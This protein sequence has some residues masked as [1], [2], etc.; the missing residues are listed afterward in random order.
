[1]AYTVAP[2]TTV[3]V[4]VLSQIEVRNVTLQPAVADYPT[5]GYALTPGQGISL[6]KIYWTIPEGGQGGIA[7]VWNPTTGKVQMF[8]DYDVQGVPL[9]LGS[10]SVAATQSTYTSAGLLTV[11][12]AN[13]LSPGQFIVFSNGASGT[14]IFLD[15]VMA[16]VQTATPTGYTVNFGQGLAL[17][18]TINTDTLKYQVVQ[19]AAGNLLQAQ[20]LPA[21]ITGVL[22][23]AI[24]LTI[25]QANSLSPGQFVVLGGTFKAA[26][27]YASG[28]VVQVTSATA[29][30]WTAKWQGT[31]IAQ[32]SSEVATSALLVTNGNTPVIASQ[33]IFGAITNTLAV[34]SDATHAGLITL[35]SAQNFAAGNILAIQGVGVNTT[36]N[37]TVATVIASGLTNATIKANGWTVIENT[38]AETVGTAS[39]L[40]G[41]SGGSLSPLVE[42]PAG[43]DLS[44]YNFNLLLLGN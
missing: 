29:S 10:L 16:Q 28:A 37:G 14:G 2:S 23:T 7:P 30:G 17:A 32:T 31:I 6:N 40:S 15:G 26:S 22:A 21:P 36:L 44:A 27:L 11:V 34:A 1:M 19:V 24:L 13:S 42:V 5:G 9:T 33:F 35:T 8:S 41:G 12:G 20:L 3:P 43:T 25:T 18:Y 38:Q 4:S 39:L